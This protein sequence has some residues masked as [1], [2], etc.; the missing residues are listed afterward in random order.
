MLQN[1]YH[2]S[3]TL[4]INSPQNADMISTSTFWSIGRAVMSPRHNCISRSPL[5][6]NTYTRDA[7]LNSGSLPDIV[8]SHNNTPNHIIIINHYNHEFVASI[9]HILRELLILIKGGLAGRCRS[10][11]DI[12]FKRINSVQNCG[13]VFTRVGKVG[14]RMP[15]ETDKFACLTLHA[16]QVMH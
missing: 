10:S 9:D 4:W 13:Y 7:I 12:Y 1:Y 5:G 16:V 2:H 3:T 11:V 15:Q 6:V 8:T 14:M